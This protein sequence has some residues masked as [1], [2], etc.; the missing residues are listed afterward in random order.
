MTTCSQ[1]KSQ[2]LTRPLQYPYNRRVA[3]HPVTVPPRNRK[4]KLRRTM[5]GYFFNLEKKHAG[6]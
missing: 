3:R 5:S 6:Q 1:A 4:R 2:I